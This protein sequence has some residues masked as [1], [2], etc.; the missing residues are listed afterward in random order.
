MKSTNRIITR[1]ILI[2]TLIAL[3]STLVNAITVSDGFR[4]GLLGINNFFS[5]QQFQPYAQAID[6]FFFA[7]LF[8]AIY[9]MGAR[10]AFK[11]VKRPEQVI[12]ILLGLMT[13]FLLVL[14]GWSAT[15]LLPYIHW[16]FYILLFALWYWLLKGIKSKFWRFLLALLL[17]LLSIYLL[18]L[19]L[20]GFVAPDT[21]GYV[22]PFFESLKGISFPE[23]PGPP[24]IPS[25]ISDLFG[26][27]GEP[28][29][30]PSTLPPA[31]TPTPG[32][33]GFFGFLKNWWW[34]IA[35]ILLL[36]FLIARLRRRGQPQ[37]PENVDE[38]KN[39]IN[40]F[41]NRK[42]QAMRK[43]IDAFRKK[44]ELFR[45]ATRI[46]AYL[47]AVDDP[48]LLWGD[49]NRRRL[50]EEKA[51][52]TEI[53][54]E[55]F[56]LIDGLTDLKKVEIEI[57]RIFDTWVPRI[58]RAIP[59]FTNLQ[60][61][62]NAI[63]ELIGG[64][65]L[66]YNINNLTPQG[67][68]SLLYLIFD[69]EKHD[70]TLAKELEEL[71]TEDNAHIQALMND[72]FRTVNKDEIRF[73]SYLESERLLIIELDRKVGLQIQKLND[74]QEAIG[75]ELTTITPPT[76]PTPT[77]PT[78]S[79]KYNPIFNPAIIKFEDPSIVDPVKP[80]IDVIFE[81]TEPPKLL[82]DLSPGFQRIKNQLDLSSCTSFATGSIF[83]YLHKA[84]LNRGDI[85]ISELFIYYYSRYPNLTRMNV[86]TFRSIACQMLI[87][88]GDCVEKLWSYEP[89]NTGKF[90]REPARE[91]QADA[92]DR[93]IIAAHYVIATH[94]EALI[95]TLS[96]AYPICIGIFVRASFMNAGAY[97][98]PNMAEPH[99]G[100]HAI[101]I[102]G[103]KSD[104]QTP[105]GRT[106]EA[107]KIRNSWGPR[108]GEEGYAWINADGLIE[109]IKERGDPPR[110]MT[111]KDYGKK[112]ARTKEI[113][114]TPIK[115]ESPKRPLSS[116]GTVRIRATTDNG[117]KVWA[118]KLILEID[119]PLAGITKDVIDVPAGLNNM[120]PGMYKV[121][122]I[123]GGPSNRVKNP[124]Q[125]KELKPGETIEFVF[126]FET[127]SKPK[128]KQH[129]LILKPTNSTPEGPIEII[130]AYHDA[131]GPKDEW[132]KIGKVP[133]EHKGM[134]NIL[135]EETSINV[136]FQ[137]VICF[138]KY[139]NP[140]KTQEI[141]KFRI[142]KNKNSNIFVA[143]NGAEVSDNSFIDK[144]V[145]EL[146][147]NEY[148]FDV[149][150]DFRELDLLPREQYLSRFK[151]TILKLRRS[152]PPG[153]GEP[154]PSPERLQELSL[155]IF[156][157]MN[158]KKNSDLDFERV[159]KAVKSEFKADIV[160]IDIVPIG[161]KKSKQPWTLA[162][163][164]TQES[165]GILIPNL[166]NYYR[167]YWPISEERMSVQLTLAVEELYEFNNYPTYRFPSLN[168]FKA[169]PEVQ[170][171]SKNIRRGNLEVP[172]LVIGKILKKGIIE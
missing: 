73:G 50:R 105:D 17:T 21:S 102:V 129:I 51:E 35:L 168:N 13:A 104:Y 45:D 1:T 79:P 55:E 152:L 128:E 53:L 169:L 7:L 83:E 36:L 85:D 154:K 144:G 120:T 61:I 9:M 31:P 84:K 26:P 16:L 47:N 130:G 62:V 94:K 115:P 110:I 25:A 65:R 148:A 142:F 149:N 100:G 59:S 58:V 145:R 69:E 57:Y 23:L 160:P 32:D 97:Y 165:S 147:I 164:K 95:R 66:P 103:Y 48:A 96:H 3:F 150:L 137:V 92:S 157:E 124:E 43:I 12:V 109:L 52:V 163:L 132:I 172:T 41:I 127:E 77:P 49:D 63:R 8:I 46:Q 11:E 119:E 67:I 34:I 101:V 123:S 107:F 86:G 19:L 75:G 70:I 90:T 40:D 134:N 114:Y 30:G 125:E 18:S 122:Y 28:P 56:K 153:P 146:R 44:I 78:E 112:V 80:N 2:L 156:K 135:L 37:Q 159:R 22:A 76:P 155:N 39:K 166:K 14:A 74:L 117:T 133:R 87:D 54:E 141:N 15:I 64:K 136:E 68:M 158:N 38:I 113:P 138:F 10:Y 91:A 81:P 5:G 139:M 82:I 98:E 167:K 4:S 93:K 111:E 6:F 99:G 170:I 116:P 27:P 143:I 60:A 108:W 126:N 171:I 88:K 162:A 29:T 151:N 24:G 20:S 161:P 42:H 121:K 140:E 71:L 72:K 118:G 89:A 33:G 106:V 131:Y